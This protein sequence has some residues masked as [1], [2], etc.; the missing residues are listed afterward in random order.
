M[1]LCVGGGGQVLPTEDAGPCK[2]PA[3]WVTRPAGPKLAAKKRERERKTVLGYVACVTESA[4]KAPYNAGSAFGMAGAGRQITEGRS[5]GLLR[6]SPE[7]VC[8]RGEGHRTQGLPHDCRILKRPATCWDTPTHRRRALRRAGRRNRFG[9]LGPQAKGP[10]GH[11][12]DAFVSLQLA[13][14]IVTP[15]PHPQSLPDDRLT[16]GCRRGLVMTLALCL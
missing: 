6:T 1:R 4:F 14:P 10:A 16:W 7:R 12:S 5:G 8:F 9:L 11:L 3:L 15:P 13:T 2:Q